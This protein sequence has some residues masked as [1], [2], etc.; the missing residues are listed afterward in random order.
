MPVCPPRRSEGHSTVSTRAE[1]GCPW[2]AGLSDLVRQQRPESHHIAPRGERKF[3]LTSN[4]NICMV[5][6]YKEPRADSFAWSSWSMWLAAGGTGLPDAPC[7]FPMWRR[8][9]SPGWKASSSSSL[10]L[11][12]AAQVLSPVS[13]TMW[14]PGSYLE[15][16][17][18]VG[19]LSGHHC[20]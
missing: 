5:C 3:V 6:L 19:S 9:S 16:T 2:N 14:P 18:G 11:P 15:G 17:L 20:W 12:E 4:E 7:S 13:R 8:L 1:P 10:V